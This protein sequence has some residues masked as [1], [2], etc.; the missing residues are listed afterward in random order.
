MPSLVIIGQ[1][2]KEKRRG[3]QCASPAYMVPKYPS[4]NRGQPLKDYAFLE[5]V[6][7]G[8]GRGVILPHLGKIW[9]GQLSKLGKLIAYLMLQKIWKFENR[10]IC[11]D[12][13]MVFCSV[14]YLPH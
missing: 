11:N 3:A 8:G 7:L 5:W 9:S 6:S 10:M 4:M 12:V 2:I 1:Q 13:I 14:F